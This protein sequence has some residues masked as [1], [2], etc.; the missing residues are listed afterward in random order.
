MYM[1]ESSTQTPQ[2]MTDFLTTINSTRRTYIYTQYIHKCRSL[3]PLSLT[4][5][6][7]GSLLSCARVRTCALSIPT[8]LFLL[9]S[10]VGAPISQMAH[11]A[12]VNQ[13]AHCHHLPRSSSDGNCTARHIC[14]R[15]HFHRSVPLWRPCQFLPILVNHGFIFTTCVRTNIIRIKYMSTARAMV[16]S[17]QIRTIQAYPWGKSWL[18]IL[19]SIEVVSLCAK[20]TVQNDPFVCASASSVPDCTAN[21]LNS[22]NARTHTFPVLSL[23]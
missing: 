14:L 9:S 1:I 6:V 23:A 4:L 2:S 18:F 13:C 19:W 15:C 22:L 21:L 3:F 7:R 16:I 8:S 11:A 12:H 10:F 17:G 5:C 20:V